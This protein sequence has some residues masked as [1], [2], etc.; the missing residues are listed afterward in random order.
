VPRPHWRPAD[1]YAGLVTLSLGLLSP[2]I[3]LDQLTDWAWADL[4]IIALIVI[5]VVMLGAFVLIER[6][7]GERALVPPDVMRNRDFS[8]ACLTV[9]LLPAIYF[10]VL[11]FVPQFMERFSAIA[12]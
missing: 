9:L 5:C 3:A 1:N 7:L 11:V 2:L 6:R 10:A 4:R 8:A 12:R